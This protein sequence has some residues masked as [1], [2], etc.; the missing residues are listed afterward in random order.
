MLTVNACASPPAARISATVVSSEPAGWWSPSRSVRAAQITRPPSPAKSRAISAPMP[1]EAPVTTT[2]LPSSFL[3]GTSPRPGAPAPGRPCGSHRGP[4][5]AP[6][7]QS[8]TPWPTLRKTVSPKGEPL[9]ISP[10]RFRETPDGRGPPTTPTVA[11]RSL[12]EGPHEG[13]VC[14]VRAA[15]KRGGASRQRTP[16]RRDLSWHLRRACPRRARRG[17]KG[18]A[19]CAR[20][21]PAA[22]VAPRGHAFVGS[23]AVRRV[24]WR[25][26]CAGT[27]HEPPPAHRV[28]GGAAEIHV[29]QLHVWQRDDRGDRRPQGESAPSTPW[30]HDH[31]APVREPL[32]ARRHRRPRELR[33]GTGEV[34]APWGFRTFETAISP[35]TSRFWAAA[36]R[37]GPF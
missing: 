37:C 10:A 28:T 34:L 29:S 33:L 35:T 6:R 31:R 16:G 3:I 23:R 9:G 30:A 1:R 27:R 2:T 22:L 12:K 15:W 25:P 20:H 8:I 21:G 11:P 13:R 26:G 14:V 19:A 17:S 18:D 36:R 4:R 24:R 7:R 32:P 5:L